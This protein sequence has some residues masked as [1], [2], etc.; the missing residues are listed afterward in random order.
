M[1]TINVPSIA[2]VITA[3]FILALAYYRSRARSQKE[4]RLFQEM[5]SKWDGKITRSFLYGQKLKMIRDNLGV[6]VYT[7]AGS[8]NS[9][10]RSF[11]V[12]DV[13]VPE[14]YRMK[15]YREARLFGIGT[16]FGQDIRS[17]NPELDESFVIQGKDELVVRS[18]LTED[19][20][21]LLLEFKDDG[22]KLEFGAKKL[23]L[24]VGRELEQEQEY[25]RLISLA[26]AIVKKAYERRGMSL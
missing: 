4:K 22:I 21:K 18:L 16:V 1:P 20:Q 26:L 8:K 11:V 19:V 14:N 13:D 17:N 10:P 24:C 9:P 3:I 15:I 23:E 6:V 12:A 5:A 2:F 7:Q 25:D